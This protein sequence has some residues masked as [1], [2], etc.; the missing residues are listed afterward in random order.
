MDSG[1]AAH[2]R[3]RA[4]RDAER[5]AQHPGNAN[6]ENGIDL[7]IYRLDGNRAVTSPATADTLVNGKF[8]GP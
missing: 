6:P 1:S 8:A 3:R 4:K 5:A 2:R 7:A